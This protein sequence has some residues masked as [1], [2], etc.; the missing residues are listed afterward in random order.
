M[1]Q[2]VG[3]ALTFWPEDQVAGRLWGEEIILPFGLSGRRCGGRRA[4]GWRR[5]P[6]LHRGAA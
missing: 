1:G 4:F 5:R 3:F 2:C 6:T